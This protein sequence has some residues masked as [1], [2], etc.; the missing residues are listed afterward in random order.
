[1]ELLNPL[2]GDQFVARS[3]SF[4]GT[5][6]STGTWP[7]G[8]QGVVVWSDQA[9]YILVGE[10]VTATTANGTPLPANTPVPFVVP[11]GTGAPWRVSAIQV[12]TGGT[13]YAKPI[14]IR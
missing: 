14:N 13:L 11:S 2:I 3:V 9:C 12:S 4:T 8:P 6:G 10:G 1:M 7:A 5:A